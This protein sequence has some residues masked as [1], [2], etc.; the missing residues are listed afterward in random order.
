MDAMDLP[1]RWSMT[2]GIALACLLFSV[3]NAEAVPPGSAKG[4]RLV[5]LPAKAPAPPD[6][7]TTAEKVALGKQLFFD[8]RLSGDNSMSCATCHLPEKAFSDGLALGKG[9]GGKRLVRNTP[10]V[11][12]SAFLSSYFWDGRAG[13]LEE[14]ALGPITAPAEMNQK[15]DDLEKEL[16]AVAGYVTQFQAVFGTGVTRK[17]V[18]RALAA[19]QRTLITRNSPLDRY[20]QGDK[21][22]L[23]ERARKGMELFAGEANCVRCHNGPLLSDGK[24]YRLG[25]S[26]RDHGRG[27]VTGKKKDQYAFRTAPLRDVARTGP[28]MHNGSIR[29]LEEVVLYYLR[30]VPLEAPDGLPLDVAPRLSESFS[31]FDPIVAFLESLSGELPKIEP[32]KL[33]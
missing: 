11:L 33:P 8:P 19:F 4:K 7:P 10:T 23:S 30:S 32:P 31:D 6:N 20:L 5:P 24:F 9:A 15:L 3:L 18:A 25:V 16:N 26:F 21:G 1:G 2:V 28:Y 17:G 22:A 14:Q 13:S 27:A 12:N 29:T